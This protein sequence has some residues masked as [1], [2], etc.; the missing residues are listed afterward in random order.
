MLSVSDPTWYP[1]ASSDDLPR[2]IVMSIGLIAL[3]AQLSVTAIYTSLQEPF[4]VM[5]G[6]SATEYP[7]PRLAW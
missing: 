2:R 5:S 4:T 3:V 7:R 1:I 6:V